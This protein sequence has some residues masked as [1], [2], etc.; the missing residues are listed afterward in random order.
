MDGKLQL[1]LADFL[2]MG[3]GTHRCHMI[4]I[5]SLTDKT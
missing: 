5:Q 1:P 4:V 3:G 2:K